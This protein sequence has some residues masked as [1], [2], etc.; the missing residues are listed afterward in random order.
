MLAPRSSI[1]NAGGQEL[2]IDSVLAILHRLVL[3]GI[4]N[5]K[6]MGKFAAAPGDGTLAG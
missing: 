4:R 6:L 5:T 3:Q 2:G 1:F